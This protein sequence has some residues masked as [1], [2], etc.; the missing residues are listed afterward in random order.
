MTTVVR[1]SHI[2]YGRN[3]LIAVVGLV[4]NS[5]LVGN[6]HIDFCLGYVMKQAGISS[7]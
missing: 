1:K 5:Q 6:N 4:L 2:L 3:Q 7:E